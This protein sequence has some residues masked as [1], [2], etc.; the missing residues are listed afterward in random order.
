MAPRSRAPPPALI[1]RLAGRVRTAGKEPQGSQTTPTP[2]LGAG[3]RTTI[4]W[5]G[6]RYL[7]PE[8]REWI[9]RLH[10]RLGSSAGPF[11]FSGHETVA[12]RLMSGVGRSFG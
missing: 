7:N 3:V 10:R 4:K 12:R 1:R 8:L 6:G 11:R 5:R 2:F 9:E